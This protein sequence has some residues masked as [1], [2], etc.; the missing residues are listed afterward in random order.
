MQ[1]KAERRER[2]AQKLRV[3]KPI[4][5]HGPKVRKYKGYANRVQRKER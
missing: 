2:Q 4:E 5:K 3:V 1:T